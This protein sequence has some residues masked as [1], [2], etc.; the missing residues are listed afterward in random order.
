[1]TLRRLRWL[2][3]FEG[4][5]RKVND[6]AFHPGAGNSLEVSLVEQEIRST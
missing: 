2:A 5:P 4:S 6:L 3:V 1:M